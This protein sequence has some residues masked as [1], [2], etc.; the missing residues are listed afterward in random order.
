[1]HYTP[2]EIVELFRNQP[3]KTLRDN[4][5][6]PGKKMSKFTTDPLLSM[7]KPVMYHFVKEFGE[8]EILN[9]RRFKK[10]FDRHLGDIERMLPWMYKRYLDI[11][12]KS[13]TYKTIHNRLFYM[14]TEKD[15]VTGKNVNKISQEHPVNQPVLKHLNR[16]INN[17]LLGPDRVLNEQMVMKFWI[18]L[19]DEGYPTNID[20][21]IRQIDCQKIV[22]QS[23]L[24]A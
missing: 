20:G 7:L 21:F 4:S 22:C 5:S 18:Q 15:P 24:G 12:G 1:M 11:H 10:F 14:Y 17:F 6:Y 23:E 8:P 16:L 3:H 9:A 2:T 19:H 13:L